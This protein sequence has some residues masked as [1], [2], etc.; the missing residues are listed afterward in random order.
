MLSIFSKEIIEPNGPF[1]QTLELRQ[2]NFWVFP[3]FVKIHEA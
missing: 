2:G 3:G 1:S